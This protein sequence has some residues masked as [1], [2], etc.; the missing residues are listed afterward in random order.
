LSS[1]VGVPRNEMPR[2]QTPERRRGLSI[3]P[4]SKGLSVCR[5]R[6]PAKN[7]EEVWPFCPVHLS[8]MALLRRQE[9]CPT[10]GGAAQR[11][12]LAICRGS[13]KGSVHLSRLSEK[14]WPIAGAPDGPP[15]KGLAS[16]RPKERSD[17]L[18]AAIPGEERLRCLSICRRLCRNCTDI[19]AG[20]QPGK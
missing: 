14:V 1:S 5:R 12:S 3:C 9:V 18:S 11:K 17:R 2:G 16:C 7:G 4:R 15:R 6:S 8:A 10:V 13:R 20:G 19:M